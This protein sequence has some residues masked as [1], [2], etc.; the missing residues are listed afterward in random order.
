MRGKATCFRDALP[1]VSFPFIVR[2]KLPYPSSFRLTQ[3]HFPSPLP[4]FQYELLEILRAF[5]FFQFTK[6]L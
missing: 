5:F 3:A 4:S 6:S 1:H 2:G